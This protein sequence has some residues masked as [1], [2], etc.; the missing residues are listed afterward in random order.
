[1]DSAAVF[2]LLG[3]VIGRTTRYW[4]GF[5][6][7]AAPLAPPY[8]PIFEATDSFDAIRHEF[9]RSRTFLI[10]RAV[11]IACVDALADAAATA[12]RRWDENIAAGQPAPHLFL[13]GHIPSDEIGR[14][15]V[16]TIANDGY[17]RE[18]IRRVCI[19]A[20]PLECPR[21]FMLRRILPPNLRNDNVLAKVGYHQDE[22]FSALSFGDRYVPQLAFTVWMPLVPC[23]ENAP[24]LS[25][26]IG[27]DNPIVMGRPRLGWNRYIRKTYGPAS[28]WSP[29]MEPGDL[30]VFTN[31]VIHGSYVSPS[32]TKPRYSIEMRGGIGN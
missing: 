16:E 5:A 32:M 20:N 25:V 9:A 28:L 10:R 17:V 8:E 29:A 24:G 26:V 31:R 1:M 14:S 7:G 23:G 27:S 13:Q 2:S 19:W 6:E 18:L 15:A 30:L 12:Y 4:D 22:Y 21:D 3:R 11:D